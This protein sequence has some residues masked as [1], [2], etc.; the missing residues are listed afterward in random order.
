MYASKRLL[1][2]FFNALE[3]LPAADDATFAHRRS[4]SVSTLGLASGY[5]PFGE[6]GG[7][8]VVLWSRS[9]FTRSLSADTDTEGLAR[10]HIAAHA[11]WSVP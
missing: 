10:L 3:I 9:L 11:H 4:T 8:Y 1:Q 7:W 5:K 2:V 6:V